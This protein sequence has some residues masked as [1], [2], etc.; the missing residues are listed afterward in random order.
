MQKDVNLQMSEASLT[1]KYNHTKILFVS[2]HLLYMRMPIHGTSVYS[3][4]ALIIELNRLTSSCI[5]AVEPV[6][7]K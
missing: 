4:M 1:P 7:S 2:V 6:V 5:M 3:L